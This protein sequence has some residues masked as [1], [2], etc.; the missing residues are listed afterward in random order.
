VSGHHALHGRKTDACPWK[1][2]L[3]VQPLKWRKQAPGIRHIESGAIITNKEH[4]SV[5][6]TQLA[7]LDARRTTLR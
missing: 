4:P 6:A 7:N 5:V 3:S 2:R 1:F